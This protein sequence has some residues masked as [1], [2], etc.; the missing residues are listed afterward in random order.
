MECNG[1]HRLN[2]VQTASEQN[3]MAAALHIKQKLLSGGK[4]GYQFPIMANKG[5]TKPSCRYR[6]EM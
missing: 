1:S 5:N 2:G 4:L 6:C 3:N